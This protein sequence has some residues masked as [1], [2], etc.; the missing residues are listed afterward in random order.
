MR[1]ILIKYYNQELPAILLA[2][3]DMVDNEFVSVKGLF[4]KIKDIFT[5]MN[6]QYCLVFIPWKHREKE[7]VLLP[8]SDIITIDKLIG[9]DIVSIEK[10]ISPFTEEDPYY[11]EYK[12]SNFVGYKFIYE[13]KNYIADIRN[14]CFRKPLEILYQHHPELL[15]EEFD[16]E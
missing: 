12:I 6:R 14:Q 13:Y 11:A 9:N 15:Q 7:L 2:R 3:F 1:K 10:Y 5:P 8:M 4:G 16:E